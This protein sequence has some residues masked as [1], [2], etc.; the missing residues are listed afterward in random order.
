[1]MTTLR[2]ELENSLQSADSYDKALEVAE[3]IVANTQPAI[4]SDQIWTKWEK[5][6]LAALV[7]HCGLNQDEK[8]SL[9]RIQEFLTTPDIAR[10]TIHT[11]L[12]TDE[13]K[14][15]LDKFEKALDLVPSTKEGPKNQNLMNSRWAGAISG[16][17]TR[18]NKVSVDAPE[19]FG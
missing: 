10:D 19:I 17:A 2:Q 11:C 8:P 6:L 9:V 12:Q 3:K 13:E 14:E 4:Q 16:L 1:M 18:I 7:L 15:A 5:L